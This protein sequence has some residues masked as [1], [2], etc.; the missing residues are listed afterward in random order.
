[1]AFLMEYAAAVCAM[2]EPCCESE[3]LGYDGS[4]CTTWFRK[5]T[6][7]YFRG[8]YSAADAAS[9]LAKLAEVRASDRNRCANEL[10]FD[11]ATLRSECQKAFGA[12]ARDGAAPGEKCL[13]AGDCARSSGET[14]ICYS[15]TCVLQPR[16]A[17]GDGPCAAGG[18][19]GLPHELFTCEA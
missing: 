7:A 1:D 13:L 15:G 18:N 3:G 8:D 2:Y 12:S 16:G 14:V 9:C 17:A 6:T 4:G 10:N 11:L 5:V 19:L